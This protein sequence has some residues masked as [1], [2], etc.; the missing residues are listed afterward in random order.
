MKRLRLVPTAAAAGVLFFANVALSQPAPPAPPTAQAPTPTA[1]APPPPLSEALTGDAKA[2]YDAARLLFGSGDFAGAA[3]KMQRAYELSKEPRL[4][5]NIAS[6]EMKLRHYARVAPLVDRYLTDAVNLLTPEEM[7]EAREV[8]RV[9]RPYVTR[10]TVNVDQPEATVTV[11]DSVVGKSPL[12]APVPVDMGSRVV[13]VTKDGFVPFTETR[14]IPG[15]SELVLDIHL[16]AAARDG[17]LV[18]MAGSA[19]QISIDGVSRGVGQVNESM[20]SGTHHIHVTAS[21]M[22]P[23]DEDV[24]VKEGETRTAQVTLQPEGGSKTWLWLTLAGVAVV[25]SAVTLGLV[26][27]S[28]SEPTVAPARPGTMGV[29]ELGW[30]RWAR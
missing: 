26:L 3:F 23:H 20:P 16:V 12:S 29:I 11:D 28:K 8:L 27:S 5:W 7:A 18:I 13:R 22:K 4:L 15:D 1:P 6:C 21:G 17:R 14:E 24:F 25:G 10:V 30:G 19:D 2:A 9:I